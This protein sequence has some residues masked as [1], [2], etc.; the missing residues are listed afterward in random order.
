[1][2]CLDEWGDQCS[3]EPTVYK[4]QRLSPGPG[5]GPW[6]SEDQCDMAFVLPLSQWEWVFMFH[7][8]MVGSWLDQEYYNY[9]LHLGLF[10]M[11]PFSTSFRMSEFFQCPTRWMKQQPILQLLF[12]ILRFCKI[13]ERIRTSGSKSVW[14]PCPQRLTAAPPC[15]VSA[16]EA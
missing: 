12:G 3:C 13:G 10:E 14:N 2:T 16:G 7:D 15:L 4:D 5:P 8:T 6:W 11:P 9:S 1:M